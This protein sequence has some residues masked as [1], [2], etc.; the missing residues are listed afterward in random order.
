[1]SKAQLFP[2]LSFGANMGTGY[3]HMSNRTNDSFRSQLRNN[4][5]NSI[6]FNLRIPIFNRFQVRNSIQNAQIALENN[7]LEMDKTKL[8]LRKRIEQAYYNALGSQEPLGGCQ[9]NRK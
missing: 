9:K 5:S 3:Y 7:R 4:M 6:G 8:D 2:T 1:M